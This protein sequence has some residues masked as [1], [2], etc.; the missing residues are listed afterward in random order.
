MEFALGLAT[1][2]SC[3][4]WKQ[5]WISPEKKFVLGGRDAHKLDLHVSHR[6]GERESSIKRLLNGFSTKCRGFKTICSNLWEVVRFSFYVPGFY[7]SPHKK[8]TR[9]DALLIR[10]PICRFDMIWHRH[11]GE[12]LKSKLRMQHTTLSALLS[13]DGWRGS[14][15]W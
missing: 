3:G 1:W 14:I 12:Q 4:C 10:D 5:S 2:K 6:E 8:L 7:I 15:K 9:L 11:R 13:M